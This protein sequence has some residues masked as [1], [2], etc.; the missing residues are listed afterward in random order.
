VA[1]S[2]VPAVRLIVQLGGNGGEPARLVAGKE[3]PTP[4]PVR[5]RPGWGTDAD[6]SLAVEEMDTTPLHLL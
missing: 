5:C 1:A 3:L 2:G 6:Q 4:G